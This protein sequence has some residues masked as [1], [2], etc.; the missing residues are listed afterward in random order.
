MEACASAHH[1]GWAIGDRGHDVRLIPPTHVKP[2]VKRHKNDMADTKASAE[3]ASWPTMRFVAVKIEAQQASAI[4]YRTRNLLVGQRTQT[5]NTLRGHLAEHGLVAPTGAA[6]I[7]R[8]EAL[9]GQ[10]IALRAS[11]EDGMLDAWMPLWG[12]PACYAVT[13]V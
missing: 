1:L 13:A 12:G 8:L 10:L 11:G 7:R 4:A 3:A 6:H 2:F 5:I 9:T